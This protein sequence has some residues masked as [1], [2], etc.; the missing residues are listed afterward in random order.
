MDN[1]TLSLAYNKCSIGDK[2]FVSAD[3]LAWENQVS[4]W[5]N[6]RYKKF[7]VKMVKKMVM[8]RWHGF[9][10]S[11]FLCHVL[12]WFLFAWLLSNAFSF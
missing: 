7:R 3:L 6:L 8:G 9:K 12:F 1:L 11:L 4:A 10:A 5:E 2:I